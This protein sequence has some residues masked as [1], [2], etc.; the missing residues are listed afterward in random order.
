MTPHPQFVPADR[1]L[2]VLG[3]TAPCVRSIASEFLDLSLESMPIACDKR[4]PL[5]ADTGFARPS[6]LLLL[7]VR[8]CAYA[9][10]VDCARGA[11]IREMRGLAPRSGRS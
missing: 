11:A 5:S 10:C 8:V 4:R 6:F 1:V 7:C 2:S 3:F 9:E